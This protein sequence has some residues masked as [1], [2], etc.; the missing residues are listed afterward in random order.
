MREPAA[1]SGRQSLYHWRGSGWMM[2]MPLGARAAEIWFT[3]SSVL[4]GLRVNWIGSAV[5][6][7]YGL[8]GFYGFYAVKW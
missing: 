4:Y 7:G 3:I 8:V 2:S 1:A 5:R 6:V